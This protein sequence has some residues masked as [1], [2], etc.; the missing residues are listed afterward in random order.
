MLPRPGG[1]GLADGTPGLC[2]KGTKV[3]DDLLLGEVPGG[4]AEVRAGPGGVPGEDLPDP[5]TSHTEEVADLLQ[6]RA[7]S[8]E[9]RATARTE[10]LTTGTGKDR[11]E[12]A[13]LPRCYESKLLVARHPHQAQHTRVRD[14]ERTSDPLPV[15][16]HEVIRP[17]CRR[18]VTE[19]ARRETGPG[20]SPGTSPSTTSW[21]ATTPVW[22][23]DVVDTFMDAGR[24]G[25]HVPRP[26]LGD[27][28]AKVDDIHV[29]GAVAV[30]L[31][32]GH[33]EDTV[34]GRGKGQGADPVSSTTS[35]V[36]QRATSSRAS[37]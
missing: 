5:L 37:S 18:G 32:G 21:P 14:A 36:A 29:K 7:E 24:G 16:L 6:R 13:R 35:A 9:A 15:E 10:V 12:V 1:E 28:V 4:G 17:V 34:A 2:V 30:R 8:V 11:V 31:G 3:F 23:H 33:G 22:G 27:V 26:H 19:E 20:T 25:E